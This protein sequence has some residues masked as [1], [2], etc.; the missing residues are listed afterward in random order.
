MLC[1][2]TVKS[3]KRPQVV[4]F[5][6]DR[7]PDQLLDVLQGASA[8]TAAAAAAAVSAQ[9]GSPKFQMTQRILISISQ[10]QYIPVHTEKEHTYIIIGMC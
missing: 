8:D 10:Q 1:E 4:K 3:H 7:L 5:L 2:V 9:L 6:F